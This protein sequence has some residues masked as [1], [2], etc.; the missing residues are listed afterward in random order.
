MIIE[1][2]M[3]LKVHLVMDIG[4]RGSFGVYFLGGRHNKHTHTHAHIHAYKHI[5]YDII[6]TV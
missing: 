5:H 6:V 3:Y 2:M 1:W 4:M